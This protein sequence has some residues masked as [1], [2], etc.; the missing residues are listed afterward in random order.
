MIKNVTCYVYVVSMRLKSLLIRA[1]PVNVVAWLVAVVVF[2]S[3]VS[4]K[5]VTYFQGSGGLDTARYTTL[6]AITPTVSRIQADDILAVVV[7][8]LNEES[9][10]LF[11]ISNTYGIAQSGGSSGGGSQTLGYLVDPVG[12]I[13]LPLLGKVTVLGLTLEEAGGL[14]KTKLST[15]IKEPTV[16]VRHLNHKFTVLGEVGRPGVYNLVNDHTTLPELIAMAGDLTIFGRRDNIMLIRS[17]NG[18]REI[19]KIDIRDRQFMNSPYYFIQNNDMVYVETGKGKFSSADRA[20][21]L[22][23]FALSITSTIFVLINFFLR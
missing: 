12:R 1:C 16:N 10:A 13:E 8:S 3:C 5:T 17:T 11:N 19:V 6:A 15:Y 18:K 14:I 9:N 4:S 20:I 2:S 22:A 23:P 21:Q 7:T